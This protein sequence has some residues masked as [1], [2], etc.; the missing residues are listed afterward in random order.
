MALQKAMRLTEGLI[1]FLQ[2]GGAKIRSKYI[3]EELK[4]DA[5]DPKKEFLRG[6]IAGVTLYHRKNTGGQVID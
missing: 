5:V 1:V 4:R 3:K 6:M 2:E